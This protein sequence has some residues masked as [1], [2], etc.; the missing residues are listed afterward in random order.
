MNSLTDILSRPDARRAALTWDTVAWLSAIATV[1]AAAALA[2]VTLPDVLVLP[3]LALTLFAA[4]LVP[5]AATRH[6]TADRREW[7]RLLAGML[8]AFGVLASVL[9]DLD[10][11]VSYL[12]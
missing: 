9:A 4:S 8:F 11:A 7:A 6:S 1:V 2:I 10:R 5:L 3:A 12:S